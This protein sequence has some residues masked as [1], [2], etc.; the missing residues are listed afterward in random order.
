MFN[1]FFT[2]KNPANGKTETRREGTPEGFENRAEATAYMEEMKE[3]SMALG[4]C[5]YAEALHVETVSHE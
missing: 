3:Q 4:C 1:I 5:D 2:E